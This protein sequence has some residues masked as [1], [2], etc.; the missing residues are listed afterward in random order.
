MKAFDY[1]I[2]GA[3]TSGCVLANRLC[4]NPDNSVLL[5]EAGARDVHPYI[6]LPGAYSMNHKTGHDWG[7]STE[8][9]VHL[10]N[11]KIY[12]PRGKVMG[13]CS[14]TNAMAYVRG[15]KADYDKWASMGNDGW[16]YEDVL[17]LFKKTEHYLDAKE[18]DNR[19][20]GQEGEL[21]VS[22]KTRFRTV[23]G[24]AFIDACK[25]LGMP[26]NH[27]YN[28]ANQKGVGPFQF[29]I[30]RGKRQSGAVAF[31]KPI[32]K[33]SN[34]VISTKSLV[35]QI[36]IDNNV[37][38][39]VVYSKGGKTITATAK[40]EI[41]V[42]AG[43]FQTPQILM[44]SGIGDRQELA[45]HKIDTRVELS[46][47]G[48]NLQD[49]LF[50]GVGASVKNQDALNH[51]IPMEGQLKGLV[52]YL[53]SKTGPLNSSP[54]E[55]VAFLN[56]DQPSDEVNFQMH[57]APLN[58]GKG[59]DYSPYDLKTLPTKDG[60]SILPT[61]LHP[62]SRG[63]V[64]IKSRNPKDH[65]LIQPN[66]LSEKDDLNQM[67]KGGELALEILKQDSLSKHI[68]EIVGPLDH[69]VEGIKDHLLKTVETVYHPVGT[70]KMG[71]DEMAVV[72]HQLNVHGVENL[73][74]ADASIMPK[75]VS[76][77]TNAACF[78]IGEK[79]AEM[80]LKPT[81]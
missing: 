55:S 22:E 7:F 62:K 66:F 26:E 50:F 9:Q 15:N 11:R 10:N 33:R 23:Y 67:I 32:L 13:G 31:I 41:I 20:R 18:G 2:V 46:G 37:A 39:A 29:T 44:L 54:L 42:C 71:S 58:F 19:F 25:V 1:I 76:G 69:S 30:A 70:C 48:K 6:H 63:T 68:D 56:I 5:L 81:Y 8:E 40:K 78:M 34:L 49:H 51:Y 12:L 4:Q 57:F 52:Q 36:Y 64:S 28:G 14:S 77:N 17:P 35:E 75:I 38:K 16:S 61:L 74:V 72:D 60:I 43:A 80:I 53:F 45:T 59:Y 73:R 27:D 21:L 24:D 3:G 65:P 47:V 79:A